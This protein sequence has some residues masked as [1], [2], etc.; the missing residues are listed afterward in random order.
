[1][2]S[3]EWR[4]IRG[5]EG[6]YQVSNYGRVRSFITC[7]AHPNAPRILA[8]NVRQ[9]GY[10]YCH[11][12]ERHRSV[13]RLVA[14][15]FIPNPDGLPQVNHID[16]NKRNNRADN[17]E[18]VSSQE[19]TIHAV[20]TGLKRMSDLTEATKKSVAMLNADGLVIRVFESAHEAARE[21]GIHQSQISSCCNKRPH[22]LSAG[23]F[24]WRFCDE[25]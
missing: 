14:E 4:D 6:H 23:G 13:H 16:G 1:M 15:A 3:E 2:S 10:V 7:N 22:C 5:Y 20:K 25:I 21:T 19:N 9:R 11:V 18:W 8:Q 17:L 12:G 24:V